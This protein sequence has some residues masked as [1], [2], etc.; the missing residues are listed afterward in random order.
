M[1]IYRGNQEITDL[2]LGNQTVQEVYVG[3]QKIWPA[4]GGPIEFVGDNGQSAEWAADTVQTWDFGDQGQQEGDLAIYSIATVIGQGP[5]QSTARGYTTL[6]GWGMNG[7]TSGHYIAWKRMGAGET[8][9]TFD[10]VGPWTQSAMVINF[11]RN[12]QDPVAADFAIRQRTTGNP[13]P[14]AVPQP[15]ND[16]DWVHIIGCLNSLDADLNAPTEYT[17]RGRQT[18]G[19]IILGSTLAMANRP[20]PAPNEQP[21]AFFGSIPNSTDAVQGSTLVLRKL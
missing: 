3:S 19:N 9:L 15:V 21:N 14:P 11:Y 6:H 13:A 7:D 17:R 5:T 16:G 20:D 12:V 2:R 18:G 8:S 4:A 10:A 1:S